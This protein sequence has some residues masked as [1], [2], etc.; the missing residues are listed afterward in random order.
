MYWP[1]ES[2]NARLAAPPETFGVHSEHLGLVGKPPM[3]QCSFLWCW[4]TMK[5]EARELLIGGGGSKAVGWSGGRIQASRI[6]VCK[7]PRCHSIHQGKILTGC[8][9][10]SSNLRECV[11]EAQVTRLGFVTRGSKG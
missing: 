8:V 2:H 3:P 7:S 11:Y 5:K 9:A 1:S 4:Q 10:R 6:K